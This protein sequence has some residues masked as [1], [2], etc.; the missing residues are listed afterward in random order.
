MMSKK[1]IISFLTVGFVS[2]FFLTLFLNAQ[3]I[4]KEK[5]NEALFYDK[6]ENNE[7]QCKLCPR[8]CVLLESQTGFCRAR[9]NIEGKLYSKVYGKIV[10]AHLDPI[11]KKPLFHFMPSTQTFSIATAGCNFRCKFCQ[12]WQISQ[13]SP[14]EVNYVYLSSQEVVNKALQ[15]K[16]E[17]IAFT[18][19]EPIIFYEYMLDIAK[20]AKKEGLGTLMITNG[21]INEKPLRKLA[22]YIDAA[23]V[24]LKGFTEKFY[25]DVI[26]GDL[27]SVLKSL[28]VM[29][30]EGMWIEIT[31]LIVP[32]LNDNLEDIKN[33]CRWIRDNLGSDVPLHFSRFTPM[34]RLRNL[35]YTPVE[36]LKKAIEIA[37]DAGI[38]YVY[39]GNIP[40]HK[41]NSTF[42]PNCGRRL[43]YRIGFQVLT[44][45]VDDNRCKFCG[46][47][48]PGVWRYIK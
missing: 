8:K 29:K 27:N 10:T 12:N 23:N 42:C 39:I 45:H 18:Y 37:K 41:Y 14:D 3:E 19:N 31:N 9:K 32:A 30:E 25:S 48:I 2:L 21:Y 44:N 15:S 47:E 22:K 11:E 34:Y 38:E 26:F 43:I 20:L 35:P 13:R 17:S 4:E 46:H 28:K 6:L 40:G 5:Y 7:V 1:T 24:D 16:A 33:M 36:T